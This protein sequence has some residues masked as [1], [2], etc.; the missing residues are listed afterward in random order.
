MYTQPTTVPFS[1]STV[2]KITTGSNIF[3]DGPMERVLSED[4]SRASTSIQTATPLSTSQNHVL[5]FYF[6]TVDFF[7]C[8]GHRLPTNRYVV[9]TVENGRRS[10]PRTFV[11][12]FPTT[13]SNKRFHAFFP[14]V[15]VSLICNK[16]CLWST[17]FKCKK[18]CCI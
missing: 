8:T 3:F 18:K 2:S 13:N 10:H 11:C 9:S 1:P 5:Q 15:V 4:V 6:P 17:N 16:I 12:W 14:T 7:W